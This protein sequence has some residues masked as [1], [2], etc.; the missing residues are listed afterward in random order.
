MAIRGIYVAPEDRGGNYTPLPAGTYD[1]QIMEVEQ[2][3]AKNDKPQLMVKMQV[4]SDDYHGKKATNWLWL[5]EAA[6]GFVLDLFDALRIAPQDTGE[7]D[8]AGQPIVDWDENEL[9]NRIVRYEV[10]QESYKTN[11]GEQ[12]VKNE[13]F[14]P[15]WSPLEG[16]EPEALN[17][18]DEGSE[19]DAPAPT[20]ATPPAQPAG[21]AQPPVNAPPRRRR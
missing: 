5:T 17:A 10:T 11:A 9:V 6:M 19:G 16:P 2:R 12:K 18:R 4:V 1:F 14:R 15:S 7:T 21:V 13:F 8:A 20:Q 3:V